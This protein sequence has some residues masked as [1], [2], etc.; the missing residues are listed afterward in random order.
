MRSKEITKTIAFSSR[1]NSI[2]ENIREVL[3]RNRTNLVLNQTE[4]F[5]TFISLVE[6]MELDLH[7][8]ITTNYIKI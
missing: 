3:I 7:H 4:K 2:H 6:I 1:I 8:L 5:I